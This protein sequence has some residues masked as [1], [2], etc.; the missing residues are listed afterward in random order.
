M[1][2]DLWQFE[3]MREAANYRWPL[4][5]AAAAAALAFYAYWKVQKAVLKLALA[6]AGLLLIAAGGAAA[7]LFFTN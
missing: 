1:I 4:A 3:W 7:F 2:D 5:G 6:A